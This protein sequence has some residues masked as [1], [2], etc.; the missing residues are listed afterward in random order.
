M[1]KKSAKKAAKQKRQAQNQARS[2]AQAKQNAT[3]DNSSNNT[4]NNNSKHIQQMTARMENISL[5]SNYDGQHQRHQLS[6]TPSGLSNLGST[7]YYNSV[8]QVLGQTYIL[9]SKLQ[10]R[11]GPNYQW[12]ADTVYLEVVSTKKE[13]DEEDDEHEA[14]ENASCSAFEARFKAD[15]R[16]ATLPEP[17]ALITAFINLQQE[18]F[19]GR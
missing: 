7:C 17:H 19:T 2:R 18:I 14:G 15:S 10:E 13:E 16:L 4:N 12:H 11:S 9:G 6:L 3:N 8:M 5:D 1:A